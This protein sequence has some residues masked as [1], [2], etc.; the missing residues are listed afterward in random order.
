MARRKAP[1][2][3][4]IGNP[5]MDPDAITAPHAAPDGMKR[6][7]T[8]MAL[9]QQGGGLLQLRLGRA[10]QAQGLGAAF[11]LAFNALLIYA[12]SQAGAAPDFPSSFLPAT[13][14][15]PPLFFGC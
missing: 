14:C 3:G 9:R 10:A 7:S 13:L 1:N 2:T 6:S 12:A 5:A 11:G 15:V 4:R 8:T